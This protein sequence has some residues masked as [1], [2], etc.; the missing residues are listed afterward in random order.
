MG[1]FFYL[2]KVK[3]EG[4]IP[5]Y[6]IIVNV[7]ILKIMNL[8]LMIGISLYFHI[9]NTHLC[10]KMFFCFFYMFRSIFFCEI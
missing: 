8:E 2:H 3:H 9:K 1:T 4:K 10:I 7:K 6:F 5:H